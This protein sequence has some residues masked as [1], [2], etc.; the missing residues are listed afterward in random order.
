MSNFFNSKK[1][2]WIWLLL[3]LY[4]GYEFL[5]AGWEKL[6]APTPFSAAGTLNNALKGMTGAH[7]SV[8]PW[9]GWFVKNIALPN[10]SVF[11]FLVKYGECLVGLA[12]ILGFA[13]IF[14]ASMAMFLN[15]NFLF[16][17]S[18]STNTQLILIA[19][20]IIFAGRAYA[21]YLGVDYWFRPVWRKLI[22]ADAGAKVTA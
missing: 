16:A 18:T 4:V 21:G 12:L 1:A 17:G 10:V 2:S 15:F 19:G 5:T 22:N 6:T 8:Q 3:R 9:Y 14:A 13:S 11:S 7:P 20:I